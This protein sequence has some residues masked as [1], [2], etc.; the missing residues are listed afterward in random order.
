M[1][2]LYGLLP[3]LMAWQLRRKLQPKDQEDG[4]GA[5]EAVQRLQQQW[6]PTKLSEP[7]AAQPAA[8]GQ[9]EQQRM[10]AEAPQ[11]WWQQQQ[12]EEMVPGGMPVLAGLFSAAVVIGVSRLAADAGLTSGSG[13]DTP[14]GMA[15]AF[16][17]A[18]RHN[19]GMLPEAML[20]LLQG[21]APLSVLALLQ[22]AGPL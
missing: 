12:H 1:T 8:A 4:T 7:A 15:I 9:Q 2:T 14:A 21:T 18:A 22:G 16:V 3:P 20:A 10:P 5:A 6:Q 19:P 17:E 13:S 11:P